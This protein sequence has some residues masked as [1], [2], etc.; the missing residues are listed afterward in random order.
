[1]KIIV[2][3][4]H[5]A[6]TVVKALVENFDKEEIEVQVSRTSLKI[7]QQ[8]M[9]VTA[10]SEGESLIERKSLQTLLNILNIVDEQPI[11]VIINDS[12][13]IELKSIVV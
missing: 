13:W 11:T 7:G 8:R 10:D 6:V 2:S 5:L 1:M 12:S 3:S 4:T 9:E